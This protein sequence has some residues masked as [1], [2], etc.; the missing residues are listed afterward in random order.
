MPIIHIRSEWINNKVKI[1]VEDNGIG[2]IPKNNIEGIG[3]KNI[4]NRLKMFLIRARNLRFLAT[5]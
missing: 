5:N 3:F 4:K 1:D 2:F